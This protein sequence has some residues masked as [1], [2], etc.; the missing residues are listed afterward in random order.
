MA[1]HIGYHTMVGD[2][3]VNIQLAES[4]IEGVG[5]RMTQFGLPEVVVKG[6]MGMSRRNQKWCI[7]GS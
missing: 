5:M 4:S 3:M 2:S 1:G 6:M 7:P